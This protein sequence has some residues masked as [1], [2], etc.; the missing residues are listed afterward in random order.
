MTHVQYFNTMFRFKIDNIIGEVM[1]PWNLISGNFHC[2]NNY[3]AKDHFKVLVNSWNNPIIREGGPVFLSLYWKW[4]F[5]NP[6]VL[7]PHT[8]DIYLS[9]IWHKGC[10]PLTCKPD[11]GLHNCSK[12]GL[13]KKEVW[14]LR[15][16]SHYITT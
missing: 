8:D 11:S 6:K 13:T 15:P 16:C 3:A 9:R 2:F 12:S 4:T 7:S 10:I 5:L 14:G 1:E